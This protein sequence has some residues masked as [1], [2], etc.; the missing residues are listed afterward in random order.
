MLST[1]AANRDPS[2][3]ADATEFDPARS[4]NPHLSFGHGAHFCIGAS[5]ARTELTAVFSALFRRFPS[6]RLAVDVDDLVVRADRIT[7]GVSELPVTW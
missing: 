5:L 3:F 6:L 1:A 4:P 7:G 2:A